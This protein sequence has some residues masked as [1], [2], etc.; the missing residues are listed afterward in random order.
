M[1]NDKDDWR[2]IEGNVD[3]YVESAKVASSPHINSYRQR[4]ITYSFDGT[5]KCTMS[6]GDIT[7]GK[8]YL[9]AYPRYESQETH[10]GGKLMEIAVVAPSVEEPLNIKLIQ[11]NNLDLSTSMCLV[12]NPSAANERVSDIK[13]FAGCLSLTHHVD[14]LYW[15]P[16]TGYS[17][18]I[19]IEKKSGWHNPIW[20]WHVDRS[21]PSLHRSYGMGTQDHCV[22]KS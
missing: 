17:S 5:V 14:E 13:I 4:V 3:F 12:C 19:G 1:S 9:E 20:R 7:A 10:W 11:F 21:V 16:R 18:K 8:A 6:N 15:V 22:R 2:Q